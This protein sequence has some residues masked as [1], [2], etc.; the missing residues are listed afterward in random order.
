MKKILKYILITPQV[1]IHKLRGIDISWKKDGD[2]FRYF[3][4]GW[5][6]DNIAHIG[7]K[8]RRMRMF[9]G[10]FTPLVTALFSTDE[11]KW[12]DVKG[13]DVLDIGAGMG[14]TAVYFS[15]RG[16][17]NVYGYEINDRY[18]GYALKNLELNKIKNAQI[19][20]C[21][22]SDKKVK[23]DD[24][25]LGICVP[26]EDR[27]NIGGANFKT[28]KEIIK[29]KNITNGVLK[30]DVDGF[31]YNIFKAVDSEDLR[32]FD[33]IMMEYH[34]G[35]QELVD[36]LTEAGFKVKTEKVTKVCIPYHPEQ[37]KQMDIGHIY[38]WR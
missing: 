2:F 33:Q 23:S 36:K 4:F 37:W 19:E 1:L 3:P 34:Y 12:L 14:D 8:G 21:G 20:Y 35:T 18:Y 6:K 5:L 13:R 25:I 27:E 7:Y 24:Q 32:H 16:A 15:I 38:A 17:K 29:E 31:E 10:E 30:I 11:Y 22:V 28:L 26:K 9:Y